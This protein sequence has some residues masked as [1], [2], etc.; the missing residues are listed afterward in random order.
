LRSIGAGEQPTLLAIAKKYLKQ[1]VIYCPEFEVLL[2]NLA[3]SEANG[4]ILRG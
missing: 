1:G 4:D 2:P 3:M